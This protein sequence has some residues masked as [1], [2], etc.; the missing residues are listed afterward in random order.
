MLQVTLIDPDGNSEGDCFIH[1]KL[2]SSVACPRSQF[3]DETKIQLGSV[4][5]RRHPVLPPL[6]SLTRR[7]KSLF[8]YFWGSH[9]HIHHWGGEADL[10]VQRPD[11]LNG[12]TP[13]Y[14]HNDLSPGLLS[15]MVF[16]MFSKKHIFNFPCGPV[17]KNPLCYAGWFNPWSGKKDPTCC[18]STKLTGHN[19]DPEHPPKIL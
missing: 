15:I 9:T 11:L 19:E 14:C 8:W 7:F 16:K 17:V 3:S 1:E 5:C 6:C 4:L 18:R 12:D 2:R 13:T 10:A